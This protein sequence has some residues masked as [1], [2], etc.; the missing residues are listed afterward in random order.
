MV[1]LRRNAPNLRLVATGHQPTGLPGEYVLPIGPLEVPPP[2]VTDLDKIARYPAAELFLNRLRDIGHAAIGPA[3][4]AAVGE[5]VRRL[6]GLPL[7]LELAA[8]RGRILEVQEILDR[9]G[10]RVLDLGGRNRAGQS[11]TLRE[12]IAGSYRLLEPAEQAALRQL[13]QFQH[14]WSVE[15]AEPAPARPCR[16]APR[17]IV[18]WSPCWTGWSGWAWSACAARGRPGSGCWT[19]SATSPWRR[20]RRSASSPRPGT[21]MR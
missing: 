1:W 6:G 12:A 17:A 9:Y 21:G 10:D 16:A 15:L 8:A 3:D 4:V 19:W 5:L 14:R 18:T 20:A 2:E 11:I 7:A 13:A